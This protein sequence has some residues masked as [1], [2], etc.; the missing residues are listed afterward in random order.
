MREGR[1]AVKRSTG[2]R[3]DDPDAPTD[4]LSGLLQSNLCVESWPVWDGQGNGEAKP[5]AKDAP[6]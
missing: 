5:G 3:T 6:D 4:P 1:A 2:S